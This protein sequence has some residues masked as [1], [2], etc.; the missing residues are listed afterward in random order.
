MKFRLSNT[1][2]KGVKLPGVIDVFK[3]V[4]AKW[5]T[6]WKIF[7]LVVLVVALPTALGALS[8]DLAADPSW[9]AYTSFAALIMNCALVYTA[10]AVARGHAPKLRQAYYGGT[11]R[12]VAFIVVTFWLALCLIPFLA[13]SLVL[14][15]GLAVAVSAGE[16]WLLS[17]AAILLS[18][19]S[20]LLLSRFVFGLFTIQ[21]PETTPIAALRQSWR[22]TKGNTWNLAGRIVLLV[23]AAVILL[24]LPTVGLVF[25]A[26]K[27]SSPAWL[28]LLQLLSAIIILPFAVLYLDYLYER[29]K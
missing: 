28:A 16:M 5:R 13:G 4:W 7:T 27:T 17:L 8:A 11:A 3:A 29:M 6:H 15:E 24:A 2:V 10:L 25:L 26:Q 20:L 22:L 18:L 9:S 12:L 19:P 21:A 14:T 1:K 23:V